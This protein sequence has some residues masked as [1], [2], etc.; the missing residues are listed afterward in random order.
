[1]E[2]RYTKLSNSIPNDLEGANSTIQRT[3]GQTPHCNFLD[4]ALM[5]KA[6]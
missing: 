3:L 2:S 1:M 4:K 6:E 5:T